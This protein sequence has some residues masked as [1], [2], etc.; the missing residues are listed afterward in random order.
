MATVETAYGGMTLGQKLRRLAKEQRYS[1]QALGDL[2]GVSQTMISAWMKGKW[3]PDAEQTKRLADA[4]GVSADFLLDPDVE[5]P[6]AV[7]LAPDEQTLLTVWRSVR[8]SLSI[9]KAAKLLIDARESGR[10]ALPRQ[11]QDI[12][13][14]IR[15]VTHL[16]R[17]EDLNPQPKAPSKR[18]GKTG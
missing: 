18:G 10:A 15:D 2:V 1:Q 3:K 16:G 6:S 4:L 9:D 7:S 17:I 5:D 11:A 8:D 13:N 14:E 12:S